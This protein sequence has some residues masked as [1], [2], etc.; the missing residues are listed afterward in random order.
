MKSKTTTKKAKAEQ[1]EIPMAGKGVEKIHIPDIEHAAQV[2]ED[3]K[4]DLAPAQE[5]YD[6]AKLVLLQQMALHKDKLVR[7]PNGGFSYRF[8]EK[9][10]VMKPGK[11][12]LRVISEHDAATAEAG[13]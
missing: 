13:D 10:V 12:S 2:F 11:E 3:A 9:R 1:T 8:G 6:D 5:A 4:G 7:E